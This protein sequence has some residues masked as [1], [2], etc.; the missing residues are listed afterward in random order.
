MAKSKSNPHFQRLESQRRASH[1]RVSSP[2]EN[3]SSDRTHGYDHDLDRHLDYD[4]KYDR[5]HDYDH[6][7]KR[8]YDRD[9]D[10]L[11]KS[12]PFE[13]L[14]TRLEASLQEIEFMQAKADEAAIRAD[15]TAT[16]FQRESPDPDLPTDWASGDSRALR[17][18]ETYNTTR[19]L[20]DD[21]V[22][23]AART[24]RDNEAHGART[25]R[26]NETARFP[27]GQYAAEDA[28]RSPFEDLIAR[29][30]A[31]V[32]EHDRAHARTAAGDS[33]VYDPL[34]DAHLAP[35]ELSTSSP[36]S[37]LAFA[38]ANASIWPSTARATGWAR[39]TGAADAAASSDV[40]SEG[41]SSHNTAASRSATGFD[42]Y[43]PDPLYAMV[44]GAGQMLFPPTTQAPLAPAS[45]VGSPS[46]VQDRDSR[47]DVLDD[48]PRLPVTIQDAPRNPIPDQE[49]PST[50]TK[51]V[52]LQHQPTMVRPTALGH[53]PM[54][55]IPAQPL[56]SQPYSQSQQQPRSQ[57]CA[58]SQM[59]PPHSQPSHRSS[60]EHPTVQ[61]QSSQRQ[62]LVRVP[63]GDQRAK[64]PSLDA[65]RGVDLGFDLG[66]SHEHS[67]RLERTSMRP[68][69]LPS[70]SSTPLAPAASASAISLPR[71]SQQ[72]VS[73]M[74]QQV[75]LHP[76]PAMQHPVRTRISRRAH[77]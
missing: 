32:Q 20:H 8:S 21:E 60:C 59:Q 6:E 58:A 56:Q 48:A 75:E 41:R 25:P 54:Q 47:A 71:L 55:A 43:A 10:H 27:R 2:Q 50:V 68:N 73:L 76:I 67:V 26:D 35:S 36:T 31:S 69:A 1:Q 33:F 38:Q 70:L 29:L 12:A 53:V 64:L 63:F 44:Q 18:D 22:H 62:P 37:T 72:R 61:H 42:P 16:R 46:W 23:R 77:R 57:P 11:R 19:T 39:A 74:R 4:R 3:R 28:E 30:D 13:D 65:M 9:H 66:L 45:S 7:R 34:P 15:R 14:I 17:D 52:T 49:L 24:S 40:T 5:A 51:R